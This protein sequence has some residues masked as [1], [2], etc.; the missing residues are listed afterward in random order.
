M[1]FGQLGGVINLDTNTVPGDNKIY[2]LFEADGAITPGKTVALDTTSNTSG[3]LVVAGGADGDAAFVGIYSG[4]GG[5]VP[6]TDGDTHYTGLTDA[7]DGDLIWVQT[8]GP[9]LAE[10]EG[11]TAAVSTGEAL[12]MVASGALTGTSDAALLAG[13]ASYCVALEATSGA[14]APIHVFV[15]A[16]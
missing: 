16:M 7:A 1:R 5:S 4:L 10:V 3:K 15:K 12:T 13:A 14:V 9:A 6:T 11:S 2:M 8:Y